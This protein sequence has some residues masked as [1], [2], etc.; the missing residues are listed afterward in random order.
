MDGASGTSSKLGELL[1]ARL[2]RPLETLRKELGSAKNA[3]AAAETA[4]AGVKLDPAELEGAARS[5]SSHEGGPGLRQLREG[6]MVLDSAT[7]QVAIL[8]ALMTEAVRFAQRVALFIA[9]GDSFTCWAA[10]GFTRTGGITDEQAK[11]AAIPIRLAT[12]LKYASESQQIY[13]GGS[14][15]Q[16]D[17]DQL[18]SRLGNIDPVELCAV[19]IK[20]KG[21][22]AAVFYADSGNSREGITSAEGLEIL[23][24]VAGMAVELLPVR[25]A[26]PVAAPAAPQPTPHPA[27]VHATAQPAP[28]AA[29]QAASAP[30]PV[31]AVSSPAMAAVA[32][33]TR[34]PEE[35]KLH[36]AAKRFA[37]LLVS[38]IKLYNEAKVVEGR[39]NRDLYQRLKD[40]IDRSR[41]M[42]G[43]R[44]SPKI[45][46]S[47]N[48]FFEELVNTL[49]E[50]DKASLAGFPE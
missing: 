20:N 37:R 26:K 48:Y 14:G 50:G 7:S 27:P 15:G 40:D 11:A 30:R 12:V 9:R 1:N 19:P 8:N 28:V 3:L 16:P 18:Y 41:Q 17:N 45:A 22:V 24:T 35:Q 4:L 47:T 29:P 43:Q 33:G 31:A 42:Y 13:L 34:S 25:Q 49:A 21:R 32:E 5:A 6:V 2:A 39:K 44:V 46:S 36:D 23:V 10:A 38:E